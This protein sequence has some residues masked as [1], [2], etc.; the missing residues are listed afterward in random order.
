MVRAFARTSGSLPTG[1]AR[2]DGA[3]V[4]DHEVPFA[5]RYRLAADILHG[6]AAVDGDGKGGLTHE[7]WPVLP[8]IDA[9]H[10]RLASFAVRQPETC[11]IDEQ[12]TLWNSEC[13]KSKRPT[14]RYRDTNR[15]KR[16]AQQAIDRLSEL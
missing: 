6:H 1:P 5:E 2:G 10:A 14:W 11:P 9:H 3:H 16:D 13:R 8:P 12:R 15:F 7:R 4:A